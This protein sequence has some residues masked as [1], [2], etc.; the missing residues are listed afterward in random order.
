M[1]RAHIKE[2]NICQWSDQQGINLQNK[3]Q[4]MQLNIK[5]KKLISAIK[6]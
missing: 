4:L 2:E 3:Q 1:K 5:K 6:K